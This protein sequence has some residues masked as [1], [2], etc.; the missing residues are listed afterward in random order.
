MEVTQEKPK[1]PEGMGE[2]EVVT[3]EPTSLQLLVEARTENQ[4]V[5]VE[6][7]EDAEIGTQEDVSTQ[8][9]TSS[10]LDVEV[11]KKGFQE[12]GVVTQEPTSSVLI[13]KLHLQE[14]VVGP[15][16]EEEVVSLP[17]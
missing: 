9:P 12:E 15:L 3:Q 10:P 2:Q 6:T 8:E 13:T 17:I 11:D 4:E 1:H 14:E 16:V 5:V 7:Q